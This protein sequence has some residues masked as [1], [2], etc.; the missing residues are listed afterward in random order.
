MFTISFGNTIR[1][2]LISG[3]W[4][5]EFFSVKIRTW[6]S[7]PVTPKEACRPGS[8]VWLLQGAHLPGATAVRGVSV[9][10]GARTHVQAAGVSARIDGTC[11][12]TGVV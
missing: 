12:H 2:F 8:T 5:R 11:K 3:T 9:Y 1:N 4:I 10:V 7:M 6:A